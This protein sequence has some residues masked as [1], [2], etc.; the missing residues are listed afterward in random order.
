MRREM[1]N[2]KIQMVKF[3]TM[4]KNVCHLTFGIWHL[5]EICNLDFEINK[6]EAL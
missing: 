4:K 6:K 2:D 1:A 5:F 3:K